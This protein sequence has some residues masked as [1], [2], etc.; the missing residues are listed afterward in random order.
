MTTLTPG[1]KIKDRYTLKE[2]KGSGSFGEVWLAHDDILDQDVAIKIYL[3]LD[4]RGVEE[5]KTEYVNTVGISHK[6]LLTTKHF[7]IW[8][9]RPFLIMKYCANGSV[10]N[11]AGKIVEQQLWEFIRDVANGLNHLHNLPEPIV[12]QDIKPDNILM[13][14]ENTFLITDFGIS[15]KI[16]STMRK[17]SKRAIGAGATA[18]MGPER[19]EEDPT[20]VKASDIW[21]LG[22]SIYELATGELPF[23][24]MGGGMQKNGA[25]TPTLP[26]PWSTELNFVMKACLSK[27]TWDR[28]TAD[29]VA[30]YAEGILRGEKPS[31]S[32][33]SRHANIPQPEEPEST[34]EYTEEPEQE[35]YYDEDGN[36]DFDWHE[37]LGKLAKMILWGGIITAVLGIINFFVQL[38]NSDLTGL[39]IATSL[40]E[41]ALYVILAVV[42]YRAIKKRRPDAMF[43][44][45]CF[46]FYCLISWLVSFFVSFSII[47]VIVIIW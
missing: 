22:V 17:L 24:G 45:K 35:I 7:D 41:T 43:L 19:F 6:N 20:P 23:S 1:T 47:G 25:A 3:S 42:C 32:I 30:A 11:L 34:T 10:A 39:E 2:F 21:S 37:K 16:R 44:S 40:V 9:Q 29:Q 14:D 38:N 36:I 18:Y 4:P 26:S 46:L 8:E 12:H 31:T 5:F 33:I 15:K 13:D 27:E 28:P